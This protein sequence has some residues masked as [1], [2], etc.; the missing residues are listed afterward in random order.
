MSARQQTATAVDAEL[1]IVHR[2]RERLLRAEPSPARSQLLAD[3]YDHEAWLWSQLF[4][5]SKVRL[6]WRAA[7]TAEIHARAAARGWRRRAAGEPV[8]SDVGPMWA[9]V[10]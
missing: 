3:L 1:E 7:L 4:R 8:P 6:A 10:A 2:H 5:L 9:G